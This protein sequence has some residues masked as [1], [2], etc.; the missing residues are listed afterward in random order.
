ML[1]I[2]EFINNGIQE[3][4]ENN[5]RN[6]VVVVLLFYVQGK[7]LRSCKDGHFSWAGLD[8]LSGKPVLRAHLSPVMT[9]AP[10]E[11][12]EGETKVCS[13]TEYRTQDL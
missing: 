1:H 3:Y 9:T 10:L 11:S 2:S 6:I 8:L 7:H 4:Q 13:L 5:N 12:A